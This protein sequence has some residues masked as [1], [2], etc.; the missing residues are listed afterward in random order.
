[1]KKL[2]NIKDNE[3][4]YVNDVLLPKWFNNNPY[5]FI[6]IY[7]ELLELL[8]ENKWIDLIFGI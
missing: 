6:S 2:Y 3:N 8:K 5:Q 7:R 1:M 4:V